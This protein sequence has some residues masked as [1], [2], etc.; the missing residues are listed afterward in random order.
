MNDDNDNDNNKLES[1]F[2][3]IGDAAIQLST[4][5]VHM[6]VGIGDTVID[7]VALAI[8]SLFGISWNSK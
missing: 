7:G 6:G 2:A 8:K 4:A 5:I 1:Y 3:E